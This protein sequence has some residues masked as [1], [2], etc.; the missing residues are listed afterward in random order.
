M[1]PQVLIMTERALRPRSSQPR[2]GKASRRRDTGQ[3]AN[4]DGAVKITYECG[5]VRFRGEAADIPTPQRLGND[6]RVGGASVAS[7]DL[8][9]AHWP[10]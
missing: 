3:P 1:T 6:G 10:T 9:S 5:S 8:S 4:R 2:Q 7:A